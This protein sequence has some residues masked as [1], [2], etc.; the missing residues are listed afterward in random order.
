MMQK[1]EIMRMKRRFRKGDKK[2][3][4]KFVMMEI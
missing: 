3:E 2:Q 4:E 1:E